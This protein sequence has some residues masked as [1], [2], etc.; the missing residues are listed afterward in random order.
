MKVFNRIQTPPSGLFNQSHSISKTTPG[1]A[2]VFSGGMK[3]EVED[4]DGVVKHRDDGDVNDWAGHELE[5]S[6]IR[7]GICAMDKKAK[8]KPMVSIE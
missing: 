3:T 8:S 7:V 4:E 6:R 1:G 2:G 5:T